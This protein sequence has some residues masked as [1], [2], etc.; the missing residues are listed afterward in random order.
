MA[1]RSRAFAY[2]CV[3]SVAIPH[4][5]S[6]YQTADIASERRRDCTQLFER[7]IALS[8]F[9]QVA[10]GHK[11]APAVGF[12]PTT[13]RLTADRSTTELRWIVFI[14]AAAR[15]VYLAHTRLRGKSYF[16]SI[17]IDLKKTMS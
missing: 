7:K 17:K 9:A 12:E 3:P 5:Q 2:S 16:N 11:M 10:A 15:N 1:F 4:R 6:A 14:R 8:S 13:N